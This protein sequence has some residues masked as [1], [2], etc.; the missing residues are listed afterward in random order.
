MGRSSALAVSLATAA[1]LAVGGLTTSPAADSER[2]ATNAAPAA[3]ARSAAATASGHWV[4]TWTS[5]P[6]PTEP[7]NMPPAPFTQP[8][9]VLADST[10]R[11]TVHVST[12]G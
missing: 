3:A 1:V 8:G 10:L 6:Q 12:G 5:M 4:N 7:G 2:G 11:Q 9:K